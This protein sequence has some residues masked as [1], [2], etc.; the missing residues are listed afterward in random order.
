MR[1]EQDDLDRNYWEDDLIDKLENSTQIIRPMRGVA[2]KAQKYIDI[3]FAQYIIQRKEIIKF[4]NI[5]ADMTRKNK[6]LNIHIL[7]PSNFR[8]EDIPSH[9]SSNISIKYFDSP[10]SSNEIA[11][12]IDSKSVYIMGSESENTR[13]RD[14]CFIKQIK[15]ESKLQVYAVLF[16]RMWLLE[17]SSDFG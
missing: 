17:K 14:Q 4:I 8:E 1:N 11:S 10:L 13:D 16:E 9:I 7:L 3:L 12:I 5:L 15:N 6:L 2:E